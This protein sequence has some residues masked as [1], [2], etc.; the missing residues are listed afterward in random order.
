M[1]LMHIIAQIYCSTFL[2]A[3]SKILPI[4][5]FSTMFFS[6]F[7]QTSFGVGSSVYIYCCN[8]SPTT[9]CFIWTVIFG[10]NSSYWLL[11]LGILLFAQLQV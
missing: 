3:L 2:C 11:K 4:R 6:L 1:F 7:L 10:N 5:P 9:L 8:A